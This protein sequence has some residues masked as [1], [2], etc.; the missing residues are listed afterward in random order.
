LSRFPVKNDRYNG[1]RSETGAG[2]ER[3]ADFMKKAE[4]TKRNSI[5]NKVVRAALLAVLLLL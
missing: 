1:S 2:Q 4:G 5:G 3:K